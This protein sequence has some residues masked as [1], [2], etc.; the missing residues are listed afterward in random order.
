MTSRKE[1]QSGPANCDPP[2]IDPEAIALEIARAIVVPLTR[3]IAAIAPPADHDPWIS[4]REPHA[5]PKH[6][7]CKLCRELKA[8]GDDRAAI[9]GRDHLLRRSAIDEY[10]HGTPGRTAATA[11]QTA[12]NPL[13]PWEQVKRK[14]AE[15]GLQ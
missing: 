9:V 3:L 15:A 14:W 4:H 7:R 13:S 2:P 11:P 6:A 12:T 10:L 8:K 5:L 1:G